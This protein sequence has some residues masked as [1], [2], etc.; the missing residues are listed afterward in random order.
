[1]GQ[2]TFAVTDEVFESQVLQASAPTLVD[3]WADWC[4]PCKM[5]G[6]VVEEVAAEYAEKL[7]VA[8]MDVDENPKTP[9]SLGIRGIPTLILFKDGVEAKRIVGY[10]TKEALVDELSSFIE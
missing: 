2:T 5:I 7:R 6:P 10:R 9:Q 3:F 1:M 8:K 4:G